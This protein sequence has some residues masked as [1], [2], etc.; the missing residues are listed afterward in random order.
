MQ[1]KKILIVIL[2]VASALLVF[3]YLMPMH[4]TFS[5]DVVVN[6]D[7]LIIKRTI[8]DTANWNKWYLDAHVQQAQPVSVQKF[9]EKKEELFKYNINN[10]AGYRK[11][12]QIK[13]IPKN[14]WD[15][16]LTWSETISV[17]KD[18]FK[19]FQLLFHPDDFKPGFLQNVVQ[20]KNVIEHPDQVFGGLI[21]ERKEMPATKLVTLSDTVSISELREQVTVLHEELLK[22]IPSGEIQDPNIFL[23]QYELTGD[24]SVVLC[25]AVKVKDD[26]LNVREPF[27]LMEMDEH[28]AIIIQ[29]ERPYTT[30]NE[31]IG[32]MYEWLKRNDQ[33]PATSYWVEHAASGEIAKASDQRSLT[34]IQEV[35]SLK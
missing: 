24:S 14:R 9:S 1:G 19:K 10:D 15:I 35:Y 31:D 30:I 4:R 5:A 17:R 20:F 12:G 28:P 33:R 22:K 7:E 18:I 3:L 32:I 23:S 29:T 34:I 2:T 26:F 21:F 8:T 25:V 16:Q 11:E 6:A 27:E 13:M